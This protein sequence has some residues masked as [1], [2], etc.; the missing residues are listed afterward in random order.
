MGADQLPPQPE[1]GDTKA[2][3]WTAR[4]FAH[5]WQGPVVTSRGRAG[6]VCCST[7]GCDLAGDL[8]ASLEGQ[9]SEEAQRAWEDPSPATALPFTPNCDHGAGASPSGP[10]FPLL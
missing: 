9:G 5:Q 2:G 1:M 3:I 8:F 6:E 7:L 10:R 4:P